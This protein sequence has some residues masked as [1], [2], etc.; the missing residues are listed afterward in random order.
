MRVVFK[1]YRIGKTV[2]DYVHNILVGGFFGERGK[3]AQI[4][5][6]GEEG[7]HTDA[8]LRFT[9]C[10]GIYYK[11]I[12]RREFTAGVSYLIGVYMLL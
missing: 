11:R 9:V 2:L 7:H 6:R 3:R 4:L 1:G 8:L 10:S 5:L 12:S